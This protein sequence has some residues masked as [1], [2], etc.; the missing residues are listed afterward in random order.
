MRGL[1]AERLSVWERDPEEPRAA[2]CRGPRPHTSRP[3]HNDRDA[4]SR[5]RAGIGAFTIVDG[6]TVT[7]ADLGNNF[8]VD[9][10]CLGKSRA[11]SVTQLLQELN[12]HVS[13]SYVAEDISQ[14]LDSRPEYLNSFNLVI[15]TQLPAKEL[16]RVATICA[17]RKIQLIVL[18]TYGFMGYIRLMLTELKSQSRTRSDCC[19]L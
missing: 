1:H 18:H 2:R 14:V 3:C 6:A 5:R 16:T 17:E 13:G 4:P 12:E 10:D 8:F 19:L 11:A 15:A 9:E 7:Q